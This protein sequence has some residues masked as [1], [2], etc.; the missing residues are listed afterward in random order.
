DSVNVHQLLLRT[1]QRVAG[2]G[3]I[4]LAIAIAL[5]AYTIA[6]RL[7]ALH[8]R[9][10]AVADDAQAGA[11]WAD[12]GIAAASSDKLAGP[13]M[14]L[15]GTTIVY[16]KG[17]DVAAQQTETEPVKLTCGHGS[18]CFVIATPCCRIVIA[19]VAAVWLIR[20]LGPFAALGPLEAPQHPM[21]QLD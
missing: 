9:S 5:Q 17:G 19:G 2:D 14:Q 20:R 3:D 13:G 11:A 8:S 18:N 6:H 7:L 21:V 1:G 4:A 15:A 16:V 12:L 10:G